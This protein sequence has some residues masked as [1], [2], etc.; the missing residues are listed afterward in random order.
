LYVGANISEKLLVGE[1]TLLDRLSRWRL[2]LIALGR[3]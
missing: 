1:K 3:Y 2:L